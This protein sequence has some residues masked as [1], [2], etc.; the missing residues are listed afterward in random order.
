MEIT[1]LKDEKERLR[2]RFF[3]KGNQLPILNFFSLST[4]SLVF[5]AQCEWVW[6]I[7]KQSQSKHVENYIQCSPT[8]KA[9]PLRPPFLLSLFSIGPRLLQ[10][11]SL[12]LKYFWIP[13]KLLP[14]LK[15]SFNIIM[16]IIDL[17]KR[18]FCIKHN[19]L[20]FSHDMFVDHKKFG[21]THI[22]S[23]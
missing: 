7:P 14:Y 6:S 9:C 21:D 3:T 1:I 17:P 18:I 8:T 16:I 23:K 12:Y 2:S 10:S 5:W 15:E 22:I 13:Q 11:N 20:E 4:L 19:M